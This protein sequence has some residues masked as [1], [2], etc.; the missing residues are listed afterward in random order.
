MI[1]DIGATKAEFGD[2][3]VAHFDASEF[4]A[5]LESNGTPALWRKRRLCPCIDPRTGQPAVDCLVCEEGNLWDDGSELK[6][7]CTNRVRDDVYDEAGHRI[8]GL[9]QITFPSAAVPGHLDLVQ[10]LVGV[11][12]VNSEKHVRGDQDNAARSTERLRV[13]PVFGV[14]FLEAIIGGALV[15]YETPTHYSIDAN[16]AV[17]WAIGQG[18]AAGV[19][20]TVRYT[21]RPTYA[22]WGPKSRDEGGNKMPYQVLA[23][24]F[25]FF[26]PKAVGE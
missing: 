15:S 17:V 3:A 23:R 7:L 4:D 25:D 9:T 14:E 2:Q 20:Y 22:V 1:T 21:T 10:L 19:T 6:V 18:P 8:T 13:R 12:V 16:G 24:R 26:D 5:A 11:M